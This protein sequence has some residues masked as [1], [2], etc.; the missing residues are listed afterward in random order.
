V[1]LKDLKD[2]CSGR[3]AGADIDA[4]GAVNSVIKLT[5]NADVLFDV[6]KYYLKESTDT[7]LATLANTIRLIKKATIL[8]EGHTDSDASEFYN[9]KLSENRCMAVTNKIQAL[10]GYSGDYFYE[11]KAYGESRPKVKNDTP[12]N[13][14]IN[15]RVEI[16]VLPPKD[17]YL[18]L[19]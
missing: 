1:R 18:S 5:V 11:I 3:S 13:K 7:T 15:R 14:Q 6:D 9:L 4:V 10:M 19:D 8:V 16:T 17:Y 2:E 12:E